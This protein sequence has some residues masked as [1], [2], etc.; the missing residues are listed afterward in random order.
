MID[1]QAFLT[2]LRARG[3]TISLQAG[4]IAWERPDGLA[5][6]QHRLLHQHAAEI[7]A[8]L[9]AERAIPPLYPDPLIPGPHDRCPRGHHQWRLRSDGRGWNCWACTPNVCRV[10]YRLKYPEAVVYSWAA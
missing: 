5:D 4:G 6:A 10:A 1:A 7:V 3:A 2:E 8:L 9:K